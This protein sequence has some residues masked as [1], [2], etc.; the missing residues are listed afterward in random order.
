MTFWHSV[1]AVA[2]GLIVADEI[3]ATRN[4]VLKYIMEKLNVQV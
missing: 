3:R 1:L 2:L 4:A